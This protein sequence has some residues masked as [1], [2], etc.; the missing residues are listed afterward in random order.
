M[1]KIFMSYRRADS[2]DSAGRI[3]DRLV[4]RYERPNI[5]KDV[6]S[7]PPGVNFADYIADSIKQSDIALIVIGPNWLDASA[8]WNRRRLD[9]PGDFVR[10][11]IETALR[12]GCVVIPVLVGGAKLPSARRLPE[13]LRPLLRQNGI[14][15]RRDPDF[16]LDMQRLFEAIDYWQTQPRREPPTVIIPAPAA[17]LLPTPTAPPATPVDAPMAEQQAHK[18]K[19]GVTVASTQVSGNPKTLRVKPP[20]KLL[21]LRPMTILAASL[22]L[23]VLFGVPAVV[24]GQTQFHLLIGSTKRIS[25]SPTP[26]RTP[27]YLGTVAAVAKIA[28]P[29]PFGYTT[30]NPGCDQRHWIP[31]LN[32]DMICESTAMTLTAKSSSLATVTGYVADS[33]TAYYTI[34]VT[35]SKLIGGATIELYGSQSHLA[36][37]LNQTQSGLNWTMSSTSGSE[38][39]QSGTVQTASHYD[40]TFQT[41]PNNYLGSNYS[42][43]TMSINGVQ[44]VKPEPFNVMSSGQFSL[45]SFGYLS[46]IDFVWSG[47]SSAPTSVTFSDFS[48]QAP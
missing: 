38:G 26:T 10:L 25:R 40:I 35:V 14:E 17:P 5:F 8:G 1:P 22:A 9:D 21:P 24:Y 43:M 7:I 48:L 27:N 16:A 15:V 46:Q 29:I 6:D 20:T 12:L 47:D 41:V 13:S 36:I 42:L 45:F 19:S 37:D 31:P 30:P 39:A 32:S 34:K 3:Y 23:V 4:E 44:V 18:V 28:Q 2:A 11:E 33:P